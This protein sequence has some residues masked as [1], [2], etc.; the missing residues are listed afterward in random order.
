VSVSNKLL[1]LNDR[2]P[3]LDY[4]RG[5]AIVWVILVHVFYHKQ[6]FP[7]TT[8]KSYILF[9][10]PLIFFVSG[11]SLL[12]S[13]RRDPSLR[14]FIPRRLERLLVPYAVLGVFS[15]A[16]YYGSAIG[17]HQPIEAGQLLSWLALFPTDTTVPYIG[18]YMW[19]LRPM[20]VI[21][22]LHVLLV[23]AF[24]SRY[25]SFAC[26][27]LL[28]G[29]LGLF[30][31]YGHDPLSLA[32]FV[33]FY[34]IF[35]YWGYSY[36]GAGFWR[37]RP[38]LLAILFAGVSLLLAMPRAGI[39]Y[40]DMQANKFPPNIAYGVLGLAWLTAFL[41]W[42]DAFC[43]LMD[44]LGPVR[45]FLLFFGEHSY[46][47]YLWHGVGFWLI[48]RGLVLSGAN[49]ALVRAHYAFPMAV[50]FL[51]NLPLSALL[52]RTAEVPTSYATAMVKRVFR[53][54]TLVAALPD[55]L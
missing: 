43:W 2:D 10:M 37:S 12:I 23:R 5:F 16:L 21:S 41:L 22:L 20:L 4:F 29:L 26:A 25:L 38:M 33:V 32:Q 51:L 46:T 11:A 19:F 34:S 40:V 49:D 30:S 54:R 3:F 8:L 53:R 35:L 15:L 17:Q 14:R 55:V 6:F 18:W 36:S 44:R 7:F 47:I 13:H 28:I 27:A 1:I 50:Y 31:A 24:L 9:E 52:A 39:F 45:R 48:D 42:R